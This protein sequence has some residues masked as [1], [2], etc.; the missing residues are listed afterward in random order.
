MHGAAIITLDSAVK[1][2]QFKPSVCQIVQ[3][4]HVQLSKR[5]PVQSQR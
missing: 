1:D 2:D 4:V 3:D 5:L